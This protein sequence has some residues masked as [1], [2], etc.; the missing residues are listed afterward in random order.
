MNEESSVNY[1]FCRGCD[2]RDVQQ[3]YS[4]SPRSAVCA[5]LDLATAEKS[6]NQTTCTLDQVCQVAGREDKT[7][8]PLKET[9]LNPDNFD[10]EALK[11]GIK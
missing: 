3:A 7:S 9:L 11:G 6:C 2:Y 10:V 4:L 1:E 8:L 5:G